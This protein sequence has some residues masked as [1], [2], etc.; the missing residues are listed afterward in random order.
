MKGAVNFASTK[1]M[2]RE[3]YAIVQAYK[4]VKERADWQRSSG[5]A[6]N[7]VSKVDYEG[8]R[9]YDPGYEDRDPLLIDRKVRD[10]VR[11]EIDRDGALLKAKNKR[12]EKKSRRAAA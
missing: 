7:W 12:A 11:G 1:R 9:R 3:L 8:W 4:R 6:K 2:G 10:E 5:T